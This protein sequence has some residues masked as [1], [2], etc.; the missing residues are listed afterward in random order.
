M[1]RRVP[2][3]HIDSGFPISYLA[4]LRFALLA[5]QEKSGCSMYILHTISLFSEVV[6]LLPGRISPSETLHAFPGYR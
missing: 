2:D 6:G 3:L 1:D 4:F 5:V